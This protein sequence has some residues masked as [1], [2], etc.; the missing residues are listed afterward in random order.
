M[1]TKIFDIYFYPSAMSEGRK[2]CEQKRVELGLWTPTIYTF[3][4]SEAGVE[5]EEEE[6]EGCH[7]VLVSYH[8]SSKKKESFVVV[9]CNCS[10]Y[11]EHEDFCEHIWAS[12]VFLDTHKSEHMQEFLNVEKILFNGVDGFSEYAGVEMNEFFKYIRESLGMDETEVP[13][14]PYWKREINSLRDSMRVLS[15]T[16]RGQSRDYRELYYSLEGTKRYRGQERYLSFR[17]FQK[18]LLRSGKMGRLKKYNCPTHLDA[19]REDVSNP[20]D[21]DVILTFLAYLQNYGY[22]GSEKSLAIPGLLCETALEKIDATGRM[23]YF[24]DGSIHYHSSNY[25]NLY[26]DKEKL[27][28]QP[29][30]SATEEAWVLTGGFRDGEELLRD[31]E[32]EIVNSSSYAIVRDVLRPFSIK[33]EYQPLF[34]RISSGNDVKIPK[35]HRDDLKEFIEQ[36]MNP[37]D[38]IFDESFNV[39]NEMVEGRA[40]FDISNN[41]ERLEGA[42]FFEY[43]GEKHMPLLQDKIEQDSS[44]DVFFVKDVGHEERIVEQIQVGK[45]LSYKPGALGNQ[46]VIEP[47]RFIEAVEFLKEIGVEVRA[48]GTPVVS[49]T[50]VSSSVFSGVD[51]FELESEVAFEDVKIAAPEILKIAKENQQYVRLSGNRMGILPKNWLSRYKKLKELAIKNKDGKLQF[52]ASQ[53]LILDA[54]LEE[55]AVERDADYSKTLDSFKNYKKLKMVEPSKGFKGVLRAYQ[56]SGLSWMIFLQEMNMGGCLADDM[57]L[58]KTIQV[59]AL[60]QKRKFSKNRKSKTSCIIV[61]KSVVSNWDHEAFKFTPNLKICVY[62]GMERDSLRENFADFD[63]VIMTYGILRRDVTELKE[64]HFDYAILDEAQAIKNE[65]SQSAKSVRLLKAS[66]RLALTG[67]PVENHIGELFSIFKFLLPGIFRKKISSYKNF[68][69][70]DDGTGLILKGLRPF[71][72]RRTKD[73]VLTEL[74]EKTETVLYCEMSSKQKEEY[75]KIKN[76]YKTHLSEKIEVEG[77]NKSKIHILEALTRLRQTACHPG[78]LDP[79]KVS[80]GSGKM[81]ALVGQLETIL[82]EGKRAL[83]FSQ[84]TS[85][86]SI[87]KQELEKN[88][89]L[90]SY[91]DGKTRKREEVISEFKNNP[92]IGI[93][94]ISL[95]AG[96]VGLNLTEA[97]YCF[98]LD[99]WWNPAVESQAIDRAYRIGQKNKVT[100]YKLISKN[101]VEEKIVELQ[102]QKKG[103]YEDVMFYNENLLKKITLEDVSYLFS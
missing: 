35:E 1:L 71:M 32:V 68:N 52:H 24:E 36:T 75:E 55:Q 57:G 46:Y 20:L 102:K 99:P 103:L 47:D 62:E 66:H 98:I 2:H 56:K 34:E 53:T 67:T 3:S 54:L 48:E 39:R 69:Q 96:G 37:E 73:E 14:E 87:V 42:L 82:S 5:E 25:T 72:L 27:V 59:L 101:T 95:K 50:R 90:Y 74:P 85:M 6:E 76:Y 70:I 61:P 92:E 88:S 21:Q 17:I 16:R 18:Q 79:E 84:F 10:Y 9:D 86:L 40:K 80:L 43:N 45:L 15:E 64:F 49:P 91:L 31:K 29:R 100:A 44:S 7:D 63:I 12:L 19:V 4:V 13:E 8:R 93:F 30:V 83:I 65:S 81:E 58:G 78:L 33:N 41:P 28:F 60:L 23:I 97:N 38:V 51:W 22:N 11:E 77:I 89:I 94:L 26:Y